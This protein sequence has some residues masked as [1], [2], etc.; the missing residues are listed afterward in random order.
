M[1]MQADQRHDV[2]EVVSTLRVVEVDARN[3]PRWEALVSTLSNGLIYHHPSW[4]QVLEEALGYKPVNLACEDANGQF[5]GVL[6]LF[7]KQGLFTGRQYS[8][9][10]R[11]PVGGPLAYDNRSMAILV[12]AA[13]ER[14]CD[15]P[16]AQLQLKMS[17]NALDGLVEDVVG[18]P[19]RETYILEL[20]ER[21]ELL[22]MGN[23]RNHARIKWAVNKATKLGVQVHPAETEQELRAWYGLYL[24]T[25]RW[26]AVPPRPYHFFELA[27]Q[28]LHPRGLMRLLLA[29]QY[30]AG[31]ARLLA[32]S[33]FLM[34]GQTVFYAFN[35]RRREDLSLRP[36]DAIHWRAIHDACAEGFRYYDFGEVTKDNQGL[37]EFKSKWGAEPK[38]LHRYYYPAPRELEISMLESSSRAHQLMSTVWRRLPIKATVLLSD[39]AHH[40]F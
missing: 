15:E 17:S 10:P 12:R 27:W 35:G 23:S 16:G 11:T 6:P 8:S 1:S 34:F 33:L 30:E 14:T 26:V 13:V 21:P 38:W 20:P 5:R 28:R 31:R 25:M 39:W 36:N 29:K 22:R 32:G 37:A 2:A 19:W 4:L 24:E 3:D 7:Y 40:Y 9:L 18:A